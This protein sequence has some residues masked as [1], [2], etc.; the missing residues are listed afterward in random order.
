MKKILA[1]LC[2]AV[3]ML[4]LSSC[5]GKSQDNSTDNNAAPAE[6]IKW[7]LV[8]SWP[9]NFPGLGKG[10]ETF[11]NYVNEMSG[12]RLEVRVYGAG[13][14]VPGFEVF[15]AVSS[16]SVQMGHAGAYYWKGK[17][18]AAPIFTTIPFGMN[19]TEMNAWLHYGDG[20]KLWREL[21]EPYGV[22]PFAGGSSGTQMAGWFKKEINSLE[23]FQGLKMRIPGLGG[24]VFKEVGGLP[25]TLTGGELFTALQTGAI[26][27]TEWVGP[28][29][30]LAFG[31][32]KAAKFYYHSGWHE[33][34]TMLE[35][36][37][38]KQAYEALPQDLQKIVEV[39]ARAANQDMLD[40]YTA[41]NPNA[42]RQLLE[43]HGIEM[44]PLPKDVI[45]ALK[46]ATAKVIKEKRASDEDFDRI[47][48][49]YD[50]FYQDAKAYH[51]I[52]EQEYFDNRE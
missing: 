13:E 1:S 11:A 26:D 29:N 4:A 23:D 27:A 21:Y 47:Y 44:R 25:V 50:A 8:T 39:A 43:E 31:L 6:K 12:G 10:P 42:M 37:V 18:P 24:E 48:A 35:F 19:A 5:G 14:L 15:D 2:L 41:R 38:N 40:E 51:K 9:K 20:L 3:S 45:D 49:S 36:T 33:P 52:S 30:D 34:G 46:V 16:G 32:H 7:K 28:Y 22:I 17:M